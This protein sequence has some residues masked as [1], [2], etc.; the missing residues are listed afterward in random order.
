MLDLDHVAQ[1]ACGGQAGAAPLP[2]PSPLM[3]PRPL[4]KPVGNAAR[5]VGGRIWPLTK[6]NQRL[7]LRA[8]EAQ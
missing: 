4:R 6:C 8:G 5:A 2:V 1:V 3:S 7:D